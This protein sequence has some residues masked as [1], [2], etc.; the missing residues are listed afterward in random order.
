MPNP[1][2]LGP[3]GSFAH[4][5]CPG[6]ST[7]PGGRQMLV[8]SV[9]L[10]TPLPRCGLWQVMARARSVRDS[11]VLQN[12]RNYVHSYT[13]FYVYKCMGQVSKSM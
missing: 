12:A 9:I 3:M 5:A 4:S 11:L 8:L 2:Q 6:P 1:S 10:P 7:V 13:Q